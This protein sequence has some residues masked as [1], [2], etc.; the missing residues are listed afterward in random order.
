MVVYLL[1]TIVEKVNVN[2][3]ATNFFKSEIESQ[4]EKYAGQLYFP[5]QLIGL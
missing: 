1:N 5:C 4:L 2:G 3:H